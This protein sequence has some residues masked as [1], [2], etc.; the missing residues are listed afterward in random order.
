MEKKKT[1]KGAIIFTLVVFGTLIFFVSKCTNSIFSD[2]TKTSADSLVSAIDIIQVK[3][4][5]NRK[6]DI[7]SI[8]QKNIKLK[9]VAPVETFKAYITNEYAS[10]FNM[11]TRYVEN[12]TL[13][14]AQKKFPNSY[15]D[16]D[17][18]CKE[19]KCKLIDWSGSIMEEMIK[20]NDE[21]YIDEIS[22][23]VDKLYLK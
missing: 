5:A 19:H 23:E 9:E 7:N 21:N 4:K 20:S 17:E 15:Q 2:G 10:Y 11:Q 14:D 16:Q 13:A 1:S 12:K 6:A 22:I 18:Y 8:I 3:W